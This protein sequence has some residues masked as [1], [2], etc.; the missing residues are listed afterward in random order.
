M[1][2]APSSLH[3]LSLPTEVRTQIYAELV[4]ARQN[5]RDLTDGYAEYKFHL[6]ILAVCR[7]TRSE[8][9][10]TF[11][12]ENVFCRIVTPWREAEELAVVEGRVPI[13]LVGERAM[14][15]K[16]VHLAADVYL[17]DVNYMPQSNCSLLLC[18]EDLPGFC[19]TLFYSA[20]T[21]PDLNS[22]LRLKLRLQNPDPSSCNGGCEPP[23]TRSLQRSLLEPFT[24]IKGLQAARVEGKVDDVL[25]KDFYRRIAEPYESPEQCLQK[26]D[27]LREAGLQALKAENYEQAIKLF[28]QSFGAMHIVVVGRRR[29]LWGDHHFDKVLIGG[30][31]DKQEGNYVRVV[32][33]IKLVESMVLAH[34]KLGKYDDARFWG[35]RSIAMMRDTLG[36]SADVPRPEYSASG[37]WGMIYFHT[38]MACKAMGDR[39][40]A[41]EMFRIAAD[42]LPLDTHV[43]TERDAS[44]LL[45]T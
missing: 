21:Y 16:A 18:L 32:L 17:P 4:G 42:W 30:P 14:A 40:T 22:H 15:F 41:R 7:Q 45:L 39:D 9:Q 13:V 3:F 26:C 19:K 35:M 37:S 8:A 29:H 1:D 31:Y 44:M 34:Y 12:L 10:E 33:R 28:E 27:A 11:R 5:K 23:L 25:V 20:L 2:M 38:G 24:M 43:R 36:D 6:N